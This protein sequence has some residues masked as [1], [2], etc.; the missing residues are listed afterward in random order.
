MACSIQAHNVLRDRD[1]ATPRK[2]KIKSS[3][4]RTDRCVCA[5]A[6]ATDTRLINQ[7]AAAAAVTLLLYS[8]NN[9]NKPLCSRPYK[10]SAHIE[11]EILD[12]KR[13]NM[14]AARQCYHHSREKIHT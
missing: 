6:R 1:E 5:T 12:D 13:L 14:G 4:V 10:K 3:V 11:T 2:A 9:N 7:A 8:S